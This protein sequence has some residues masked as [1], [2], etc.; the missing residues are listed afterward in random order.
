VRRWLSYYAEHFATVEVNNAFYRLPEEAT[1]DNWRRS[2]PADF[3]FAVKASRYLTHVRRL[4]EPKEP[5]HRLMA[6]AE[7][8]GP[9][10]GPVLL[11]LAP[12]HKADLDALG[13]TLDAFPR[14]VRVAFE[15][16]H[17][18]WW[19]AECRRLLE[20]HG[21]A[22]CWA[23]WDGKGPPRW[24]TADWGYV[25]LHHGKASPESCYGTAALQRWAARL[26]EAWDRA[27]D[28]YVYFN[29][30]TNGCAPHNAGQLGRRLGRLDRQP[31]RVPRPRRGG[32]FERPNTG[33]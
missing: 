15:P 7:A 22:L 23:D 2:V 25:R 5:V 1:F 9:K 8:L 29:N 17:E 18:S 20:S 10:L 3:D 28:L 21:A 19:T 6:R 26:S 12:N 30:D 14:A 27:S 32:G 13:A 31:T 11:Q 4:R 24:Q 16:R 33:T